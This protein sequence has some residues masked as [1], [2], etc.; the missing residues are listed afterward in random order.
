MNS[1]DMTST[2]SGGLLENVAHYDLEDPVNDW[3][4]DEVRE[5]GDCELIKSETGYQDGWYLVY[6]I[7]PGEDRRDNM[8][9]SDLK[10]D[11]YTAWYTGYQEKY[12]PVLLEGGLRYVNTDVAFNS[13]S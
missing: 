3:I 8:I 2:S 11:D 13:G 6:Y 1:A 12:E 4:F 9:R 5:S 7:G 10:E